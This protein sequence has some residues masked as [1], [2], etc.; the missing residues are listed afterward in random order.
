MNCKASCGVKEARHPSLCY[1]GSMYMRF[2]K[3]HDYR[4]RKQIREVLECHAEELAPLHKW[5]RAMDGLKQR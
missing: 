1:D 5:C 3:R 4:D 2:Q